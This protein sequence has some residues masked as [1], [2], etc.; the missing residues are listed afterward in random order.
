MQHKKK[1]VGIQMDTKV[2]L[3]SLFIGAKDWELLIRFLI[4]G[5]IISNSLKGT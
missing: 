4:Q 3:T 1:S 2:S 5:Q